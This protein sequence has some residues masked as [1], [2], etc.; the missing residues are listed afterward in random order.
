MAIL[1]AVPGNT[2]GGTWKYQVLPDSGRQRLG[3][4]G[5]A[6]AGLAGEG[7]RDAADKR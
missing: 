7:G 3:A 6:R 4:G 5:S 2:E 1:K